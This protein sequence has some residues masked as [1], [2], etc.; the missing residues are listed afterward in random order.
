MTRR[1]TTIDPGYFDEIY[2]ADNDPWNFASSAY[3]RE[4]YALTLSALPKAHY[5]AGL[6]VGCSIGVLTRQLGHRCEALLAIDATERPLAE[7]RRRCADLSKIHFQQMFV[8]QQR[9]QGSFDLIVLSEIIYL[10]DAADAA[11][12]ADRVRHALSP[13][14]DVVLVHWTG[15][16]NYPLTGDEA[17]ELF[18]AHLDRVTR[19]THQDR[20]RD[21]RIDVLTAV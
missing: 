1:N 15:E 18:V 11:G 3:E 6:E 19:L 16:T 4:K 20:R 2:A 5:E 14:G 7:A 10:L 8:P 21:F 17:A 13:G 9:P 12:L